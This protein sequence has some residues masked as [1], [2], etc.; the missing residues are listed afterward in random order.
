MNEESKIL[1]SPKAID[2]NQ[3]T[4]FIRWVNKEYSLEFSSYD[5]LHKWS[6]TEISEFWRAI[7]LFCGLEWFQH[8]TSTLSDSSSERML[9]HKWFPNG[10]LNYAHN[11]LTVKNKNTIQVYK[12]GSPDLLKYER[13][14][15]CGLVYDLQ[16]ELLELELSS[17]DRVAAVTSNSYEALAAML[18]A[19]SLG[20]TWSSSSPDFGTQAI[21]DRMGQISPKVLFYTPSYQYNGKQFD[22]LEK[23]PQ[24]L[25]AIPSIEKVILL[26]D[27]GINIKKVSLSKPVQWLSNISTDTPREASQIQ[28]K[29]VTFDH[30][31]FIL[32]SSGTTGVPKCIV[33]SVGGTLIQH[34]KEHILHCNIGPDSNLLYFT[35]CGWMMWNWMVSALATGASLTLFDGSV[36]APS[37]DILWKVVEKT[38]TTHFGT[39]PKFLS[40]CEQ[41]NMVPSQESD[42]SKVQCILS[43]GSPLSPEQFEWVYSKVKKDVHL[44]SIAGGTDIV[45]CFLLGNPNLPVRA[46]E[47]Q[48]K[49]LGMAVEAWDE[50]AH[51]VLETKGELVCVA[52]FPSMPIGFYGD[53]GGSKYRSAYFEAFPDKEVWHHG[54]YILIY[55]HGGIEMYGRSDATLNPGGVRIGTS[56]IYRSVERLPFVSDSIAV[57][58]PNKDD[59][60]IWLF[61]SLNEPL[62]E[63]IEKEIRIK[64][65]S[66]LSPRHVP[67][68]IFSIQDIPYTRSGKKVELAVKK[69]I[70][71]EDVPN[72]SAFR[73]PESLEHFRKYALKTD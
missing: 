69:V 72:V 9:G 19:T 17:T 29:A 3:M 55:P 42:L 21:I 37:K 46:G 20:A 2:G 36:S 70:I 45:S 44:A 61:V 7:S 66:D 56:E 31:L 50:T 63:S 34:K 73:N 25:E 53:P 54:D 14:N 39:S 57:G 13:E 16:K 64:I 58:I 1:W 6:V 62:T 30:P 10:K 15:L 38:Q 48:C 59:I 47:I 22:C 27:P 24:I 5:E 67:T 33:H 4:Q 60:E 18:A 51:S 23:L 8:P 71:G 49:G 28:Y 43:T 40:F 68:K 26:N 41:N 35:T 52:P 11:L 32:F 12:E 65:R